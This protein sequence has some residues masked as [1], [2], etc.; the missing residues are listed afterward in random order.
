[1]SKSLQDQLMGAGLIDKKKAKKIKNSSKKENHAQL[2]SRQVTTPEAK[3][4]A[5]KAI[6]EKREKDRKL[7]IEH[8]AE[9]EK[10][11]VVAQVRQLIEH[12]QVKDR[13]GELEFNFSDGKH[14]KKM[15]LEKLV[16]EKVSIGMLSVVKYD[17]RYELVP[18]PIA[19]KIRERMPEYVVVDNY[20]KRTEAEQA[21]DDEYYAQ[22]EIPDDL[23]W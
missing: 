1:M 10:K 18:R 15:R 2:K 14:I 13:K 6:D 17:E 22:F 5:Q 9:A 3:I 21:D 19:E 8:R 20:G 16:F 4:N 23:M 7:N 12:Y 11:A